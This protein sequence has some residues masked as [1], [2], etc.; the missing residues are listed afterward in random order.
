ML[1]ER[2]VLS[3]RNLQDVLGKII[4][5]INLHNYK[6]PYNLEEFK[7]EFIRISNVVFNQYEKKLVHLTEFNNILIDTILAEIKFFNEQLQKSNLSN[8]QQ[9]LQELKPIKKENSSQTEASSCKTSLLITT[10]NNNNNKNYSI[11]YNNFTIEN[12]IFPTENYNITR[13]NNTFFIN[14]ETDKQHIEYPI[15]VEPGL[16]NVEEL[17]TVINKKIGE[18]Q[19][20]GLKVIYDS[21]FTKKISI[22]N[23]NKQTFKLILNRE[24]SMFNVLGF[25]KTI[26]TGKSEYISIRSYNIGI[27]DLI[28]IEIYI[29]DILIN[30]ILYDIDKNKNLQNIKY[31]LKVCNDSEDINKVTTIKVVIKNLYH[32]LY[33]SEENNIL[34]YIS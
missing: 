12:I 23:K 2:V 29:N 13:N 20:D 34:L 25:D 5:V 22:I 19:I 30:K 32:N 14:I 17:V 33:V 1:I 21:I 27:D 4:N 9:P 26:Y 18:L 3:Q 8:N 15:I 7:T 28:Y 16:Y 11:N 6:I 31:N 10:K 24:N